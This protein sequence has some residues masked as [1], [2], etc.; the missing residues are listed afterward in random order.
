M[1][2]EARSALLVLAATTA[3][4]MWANSAWVAGYE[5]L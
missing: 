1:A 5:T 4:L 3:A 2:T